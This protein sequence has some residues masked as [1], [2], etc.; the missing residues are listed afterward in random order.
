[1]ILLGGGSCF[2]RNSSSIRFRTPFLQRVADIN[3]TVACPLQRAVI[4][5]TDGTLDA[6]DRMNDSRLLIS[7][8]ALLHNVRLLRRAL[9]PATKICAMVKADAYGHC[10]N[11]V[12][13]T[14]A[15][16]ALD[17]VD[18]PS[19][20]MLAVATIDEAADLPDVGLPILILRPVEN[21]FVGR[22]RD[23]L[24]LAIR[25]EWALTI[26]SASAADDVARVAMSCGK[27]A[28]VHVMVDTGLTRCGAAHDELPNVLRKI[29]SL[30]A[31]RLA[32]LSSHFI[33]SDVPG[34]PLADEQLERFLA[35]TDEFVASAA[36]RVARHIGNSGAIFFHSESHLDMVRPG[37][38]LYGIDPTL[39]PNF[40]RA[41]RPVMKWV[42]PLL[43]VRDVPRGTT[44][45][46]GA[47]WTAERD[48]RIGLV[49]VGY[50][51]GYA[52]AFSNRASMLVGGVSC[53]VIGRVSMDYTTIDL[54]RVPHATAGAEVTVLDNDPLSPCSAYALAGIVQTIPYEIFT[55]IGARVRRTA[56]DPADAPVAAHAE[57]D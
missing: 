57:E 29:E 28:T 39:H 17:D 13:D 5:H 16:F 31:L 1:M 19:V 42:A 15:N 44:V 40:N 34:D 48:T 37:I 56:T 30:S 38:A 11:I 18:A 8:Q 27:R 26:I 45:G 51:D 24:E 52:R 3:C 43:H 36:G 53:P 9:D 7:R 4:S 35:A 10:A 33:N 25:N 6:K 20:D 55:G 49:S 21:V 41:L 50:A 23:A 12:V 46:Y 54:A 47:T 2:G 14:L 32:G 22:N